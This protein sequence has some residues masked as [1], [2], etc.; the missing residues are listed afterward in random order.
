MISANNLTKR[1]GDKVALQGVSFEVGPGEILGYIGPNGAGKTT[2]VKILI[3]MMDEFE[4]SAAVCGV[5]VREDPLEVKRRIGYVPETS[6]L[7]D[8]LTPMEYLTFVGRLYGLPDVEIQ[9]RA[10]GMLELLGLKDE[11]ADRMS[12]F[13]KGMTQ[14]VLITAGLMHD[15][16]IIFM[17]EPLTGLDANSALV[18]KELIARLAAMGKT[19]FYCSHIMDVVERVCTRIMILDG[20]RIAA[21]GS[22]DELQGQAQGSSLE[23]IF[24]QLTGEGVHEATADQLVQLTQPEAGTREA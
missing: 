5:D 16:E 12:S 6:A 17:D 11:L 10:E 7:Y 20:G 22:F 4:G 19:V 1:F 24:T 2:T 14:K 13:S 15:P 3:G 9:R 23:Q 8:A 18:I 21:D